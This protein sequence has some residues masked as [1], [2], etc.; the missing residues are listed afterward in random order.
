MIT[1]VRGSFL[2]FPVSENCDYKIWGAGEGIFLPRGEV[3]LN[4]YMERTV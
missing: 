2:L 1:A 3:E 4:I